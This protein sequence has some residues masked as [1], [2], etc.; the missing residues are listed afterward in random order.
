MTAV[1]CRDSAAWSRYCV[2]SN[3]KICELANN[4]TTECNLDNFHVMVTLVPQS[5]WSWYQV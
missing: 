4:L 1:A 3:F 5:K 2:E